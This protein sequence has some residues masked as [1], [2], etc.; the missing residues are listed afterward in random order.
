MAYTTT[1]RTFT[2]GLGAWV[3]NTLAAWNDAAKRR[4]VYAQVRAELGYMSDRDLAD[5]NLSR[6][7]IDEIAFQA[8]YG[9]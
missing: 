5:I 8:A 4:A 9:K 3:R 6:H 2:F 1:E 7:Q